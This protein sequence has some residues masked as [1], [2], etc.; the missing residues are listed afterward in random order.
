MGVVQNETMDVARNVL[1]VAS[2]SPFYIQ[3]ISGDRPGVVG[4]RCGILR[5]RIG[6]VTTIGSDHYKSFRSLEATAKKKG[7]LVE[8]LPESGIAILNEDD[9]HVRAMAHRTRARVLTFGISSDAVVRATE[10]S[11]SWPE[12]LRLTVK[13]KNQKENVCTQLVGQFWVPS[14][15]AAIAGG[16]PVV[17]ILKPA[18]TV[19][20][21]SALRWDGVLCTSAQTMRHTFSIHIRH[22]F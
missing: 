6:I 17:S 21:T 22:L 20:V 11:G 19:C 8:R 14:V 12:R 2:F 9:P 3:E 10:V 16:L 18:P 5:P 4:E 1:K 15:L 7:V 13:Y